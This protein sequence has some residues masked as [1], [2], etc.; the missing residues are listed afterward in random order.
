MAD[1]FRAHQKR[2]PPQTLI[3][4][5]SM[6]SLTDLWRSKNY[7]KYRFLSK[8]AVD[9]LPKTEKKC[10]FAIIYDTFGSAIFAL[11]S[12]QQ[13]SIVNNGVFANRPQQSIVNI[14]VFAK[15]H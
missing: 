14:G 7:R 2:P 9:E 12:G 10:D 1:F 3:F 11:L 4:W 8:S 13:K 6:S 15:R 5:I